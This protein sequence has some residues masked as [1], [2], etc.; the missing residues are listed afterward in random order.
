MS[1][2][3]YNVQIPPAASLQGALRNASQ[4]NLEALAE[5]CA[6][7]AK[8]QDLL[9]MGKAYGISFGTTREVLEFM[10]ISLDSESASLVTANLVVLPD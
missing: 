9:L 6:C 4:K 5:L 2:K 10:R 1:T 7:I 8:H 3:E